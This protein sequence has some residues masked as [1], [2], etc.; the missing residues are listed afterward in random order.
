MVNTTPWTQLTATSWQV[1]ATTTLGNVSLTVY[2]PRHTVASQTTRDSGGQFPL[3]AWGLLL[4]PFVCKPRRAGKRLAKQA[5]RAGDFCHSL[6][7]YRWLGRMRLAQWIFRAGAPDLYCNLDSH[8]RLNLALDGPDPRS[9]VADA[10]VL[11]PTQ[12]A[13]RTDRNMSPAG[14]SELQSLVQIRIFG[15]LIWTRP[16]ID[17]ANSAEMH[18]FSDS[19][20]SDALYQGLTFSRAVPEAHEGFSP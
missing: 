10:K 2:V 13:K 14:T 8:R 18:A 12:S 6:G 3:M 1:P 17:R 16:P 5:C 20:C 19:H 15:W 9:A 11:D 7:G 4:V